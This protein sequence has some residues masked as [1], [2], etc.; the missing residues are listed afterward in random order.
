MA[1]TAGLALFRD[2]LPR[3]LAAPADG[4]LKPLFDGLNRLHSGVAND[5][6]VWMALGIAMFAGWAT[7]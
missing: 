2:R 4:V 3:A 6:V 1:A 5:Y 7:F